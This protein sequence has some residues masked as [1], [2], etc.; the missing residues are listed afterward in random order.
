MYKKAYCFFL[1]L[2]LFSCSPKVLPP[3]ETNTTVRDSIVLVYRDCVRVIPVERV[4]DVVR[5]YDSLFLETSLAKAVAYV[6]TTT[7]TLKGSIENKQ[8]IVYKYV[9]NEKIAYKDSIVYCEKPVPYEVQVPVRYVPLIYKILSII[10][11]LAL[12]S[13]IIYIVIKFK[14]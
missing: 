13:V 1:L 7:H 4:V 2:F 8:D 9:T 3:I 11:G 10:G 14:I 6:D 12:L 5:Q